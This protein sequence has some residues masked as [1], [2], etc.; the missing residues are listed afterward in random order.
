MKERIV[1]EVGGQVQNW[2]NPAVVSPLDRFMMH[3]IMQLKLRELQLELQQQKLWQ[4]IPPSP[5][6]LA[7]A[8]PFAIDTLTLH[9]WLQ[10]IFIPKVQAL[11]DTNAP[12]PQGFAISPYAEEFYG[13]ELAQRAPLIALLK[14]IDALG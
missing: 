10:F 1:G 12:M 5:E 8:Q 7:S 6:A 3:Q 13:A 9:Q 4:Q 11:I 2:Y 14:E